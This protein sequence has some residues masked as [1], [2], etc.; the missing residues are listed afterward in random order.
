MMWQVLAG[1]A[2]AWA[3]CGA[4][5]W[6]LVVWTHGLGL[7][8]FVM[9]PVALVMGPVVLRLYWKHNPPGRR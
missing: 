3:S 5:A 7:R 8:D 6:I 2:L 9:L 1:A 4:W